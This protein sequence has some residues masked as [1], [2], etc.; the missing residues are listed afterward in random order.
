MKDFMSK[1]LQLVKV[2]VKE[3]DVIEVD[4]EIALV[5]EVLENV[6]HK[7][8]KG[9]RG[10]TKAKGY[11]KG[12]K[13]AQVAFKS[14]FPFVAFFDTNVVIT[15]ANIKLCKVMRGLKFINKVWDEQETEGIFN[16]DI[17]ELL[18]VLNWVKFA[19][20]FIDK[21]DR[22][23]KRRL[24]RMDVALFEVVF[25]VVMK[26]KFFRVGEFINAFFMERGIREK[27]NGMIPWLVLWKAMRGHF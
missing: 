13:E 17:V 5:D 16:G 4:N 14:S 25:N 26:G 10:I 19:I 12:F 23:G 3:E 8:L 27:V 21:E 22:T 6:S 24:E 18:V 9:S 11:N 2:R 15:L 1:D 20:L 7:G